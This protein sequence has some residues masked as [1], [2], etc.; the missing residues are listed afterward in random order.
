MSRSRL[1]SPLRVLHRLRLRTQVLLLVNL[2]L[3]AAMAVILP[4][5]YTFEVRSRLREKEIAL[6]EEARVIEAAVG[7][8]RSSGWEAIRSHINRVCAGMSTVESP[9]H[10][11]EVRQGDMV[12]ITDPATHGHDR[13]VP[14]SE[15]VVG[16][17]VSG[18]LSIR[19]GER[20]APILADARLAASYRSMALASAAVVSAVLLNFLLVRLVTRPIERL[21]E[22]V[23]RIGRGELGL[24]VKV[25]TNRELA[26]LAGAISMMSRDLAEREADRSAQLKRARRLQRHL[27]PGSVAEMAIDVSIMYQPADEIAGDFVDVIACDNGDT[28][29]CIA[30]VVG[31]GIHAAMGAVVLKALVLA[32]EPERLSP[33]ELLDIVNR[34]F[35]AISLPEDFASMAVLRVSGDQTRARYA[36]AGHEPGL[37]RRSSGRI[38]A[39][40]STGL[41]LGVDPETG[42]EEVEIRLDV[43]DRVVLLSDGVSEAADASK[44]LFGRD[45]LAEVIEQTPGD[46]AAVLSRAILGAVSRH[47]GDA[48]ALD[49]TSVLVFA[50]QPSREEERSR[51]AVESF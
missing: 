29:L 21:S 5:D 20:R 50:A 1:V 47:R 33:A 14:W 3:A 25:T 51:L 23:K 37:V 22:G 10:T 16:G 19:V 42:Y 36:S 15:L 30:D 18:D 8:L 45:R 38:D 34:R 17:I 46:G 28:I 40:P 44:R 4:L 12:A 26:D 13:L 27:L 7:S 31:H 49:D 6:R 48:P 32:A 24:A 39:L 35:S 2:V 43:G 11:I 9:G 41:V